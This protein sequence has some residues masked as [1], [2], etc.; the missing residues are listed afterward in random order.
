[1]LDTEAVVAG[2]DPTWSPPPPGPVRARLAFRSDEP[3]EVDRL[4][5]TAVGDGHR[6]AVEPFDAFWGQRYASLL[7][8]D[9]NP[10]DL[11]AELPADE[12]PG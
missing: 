5:A 8:P 9:G 6:S 10:V 2:F 4:H 7:D 11:F 12:E 3:A 1:M